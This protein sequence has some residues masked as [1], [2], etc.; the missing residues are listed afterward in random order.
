MLMP[1]V[2]ISYLQLVRCLKSLSIRSGVEKLKVFDAVA[3]GF[4]VA[5]IPIMVLSLIQMLLIYSTL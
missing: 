4:A 2:F 3:F 1:I 5:L